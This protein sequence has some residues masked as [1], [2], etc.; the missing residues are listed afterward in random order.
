MLM[1]SPMRIPF[2]SLLIFALGGGVALSQTEAPGRHGTLE[3]VKVHGTGLEGN[4]SGDSP[5]R[6]VSIY[7]PASYKTNAN[8]RYPVV[9]MLH[10]FTDSDTH[11]YSDPKHFVNIPT[12]LD[13]AFA[14]GTTREM[15]M[16]TPNAFTRFQGSM[17][18][19][20]VT[21]G[22]WEGFVA[23]ELIAYVDSHYRTIASAG[24]RGL[25]GHSMGGYGAIRIGMKY[26]EI[27]SS[28]YLLSPCCLTPPNPSAVVA[29]GSSKAEAV[30]SVEDI[31]KADFGTKVALASA[32]AWSPNPKKAP[33]FVDL[34]IQEGQFQPAVA[35][36]WAANAPL[37]LIDQHVST[38]KQLHAL[39][40]DA[41]VQDVRIA[42]SIKV[43]DQILTDYQIVHTYET[44][45][46]NH[47][48][49]VAERIETKV[50]PFFSK[51]L[52]FERPLR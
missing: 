7:L 27:F 4:L 24:S 43:L 48:N 29:S 36:R 17:Y 46:G 42:A 6:D 14:D 30:K 40:F 22:D 31:G 10:G 15:I 2:G 45:E 25:A 18:S 35:A 20:S 51:N 13:K 1:A 50:M 49:R 41:G 3:R 11:W 28:V 38:L 37:A 32:A 47:T 33:L 19:T 34:L 52:S 26:P 23:R 12:V 44:Y 5:D 8:R 16:V 39:A 9:Y 21:I